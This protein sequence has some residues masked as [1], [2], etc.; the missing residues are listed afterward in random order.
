MQFFYLKYGV[1]QYTQQKIPITDL[2][3]IDLFIKLGSGAKEEGSVFLKS[4]T[5]QHNII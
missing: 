3:D 4:T 5:R 2:M 1:N